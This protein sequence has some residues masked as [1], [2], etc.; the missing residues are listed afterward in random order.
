[1]SLPPPNTDHRGDYA[2][3]IGQILGDAFTVS[4][5]SYLGIFFLNL[6]ILIATVAAFGSGA[7]SSTPADQAAM[8]AL[9]R[10][11]PA[12]FA[13]MEVMVLLIAVVA[14]CAMTQL[15]Y[16]RYVGAPVSGTASATDG[17]KRTLPVLGLVLIVGLVCVVVG[18]VLALI[19]GLLQAMLGTLAILLGLAVTIFV[20]YLAFPYV[21]ANVVCIIEEL[22]PIASFGRSKYL[23]DGYRWPILG[24]FAIFALVMLVYQGIIFGLGYLLTPAAFGGTILLVII[25]LAYPLL[26]GWMIGLFVIAAQRLRAIKDGIA[27]SRT[28]SNVFE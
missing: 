7:M 5:R 27:P 21:L 14:S 24:L 19:I 15:I 16:D 6:P 23:T 9:M 20:L 17:V 12:R 22:G 18:I 4:L 3:G 28:L 11:N 26:S 1:M 10:D 2:L 25:A 8:Q 13:L